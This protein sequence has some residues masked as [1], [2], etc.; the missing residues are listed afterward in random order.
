MINLALSLM[1]CFSILFTTQT[2]GQDMKKADELY[3]QGYFDTARTEYEAALKSAS[4]DYQLLARL[5][6][7]CYFKG[8]YPKAVE[9]F[10][11]SAKLGY[12][13]KKL[14]LA[15]IALAYYNARNYSEVIAVMT[16]M[17]G[18]IGGLDIEQMR[19]LAKKTPYRIEPRADSTSI[20]FEQVDPVPVIP[21]KVN[22]SNLYVL[23]DTGVDQLY[24]DS[25]FA[26]ENGI[27][28]VSKQIV[29]GFGG[30]KAG[31]V[32]YGMVDEVSLGDMT[33]RDVPVWIL[34]TRRFSEGNVRTINGVL[35]TREL[36]QFLPTL[37]YPGKRLILRLK[38]S[39]KPIGTH[40]AQV[41]VPFIIDGFHAMFS[42]CSI[43]NKGPVLMYFDSGLADDQGAS[44]VL[45]GAALS[46][47]G[48]LKPKMTGQGIGGGGENKYGYVQVDSVAVS[49]L[50]QHKLKALFHGVEGT[51]ET[52]SGYKRYGLLSHNFL[53]HYRWTIDF[54][55]R[56]FLFEQ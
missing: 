40:G 51:L 23:I 21:I 28:P 17:G 52:D 49:N 16:D 25:E 56:V 12:P 30:G 11:R 2:W 27:H 54:D 55:K 29:N 53:K 44:M 45:T 1:V 13:E 39:A 20:P 41:T 24:I 32:S 50:V 31:G 36:M 8:E 35:G 42:Q 34:P 3:R 48:I 47:L 26:K 33:I 43:N 14:L 37:D 7:I 5:G 15:Y 22:S 6:F 46:D 18:T 9:Y 4:N 38:E 10:K 19:L